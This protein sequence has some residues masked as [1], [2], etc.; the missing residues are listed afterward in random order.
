MKL[1]VAIGDALT[2]RAEYASKEPACYRVWCYGHSRR[3]GAEAVEPQSAASPS[4][5]ECCG[6]QHKGETNDA[7]DCPETVVQGIWVVRKQLLI[8]FRQ[9]GDERVRR[10]HCETKQHQEGRMSQR[11]HSLRAA[12]E[13]EMGAGQFVLFVN[14]GSVPSASFSPTGSGSQRRLNA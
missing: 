5:G 12:S 1:G 2:S 13:Q 14:T 6:R 8:Q 10:R 4:H 7:A 9:E 3:G 11:V